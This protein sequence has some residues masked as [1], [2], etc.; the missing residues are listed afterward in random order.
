MTKRQRFE[1]FQRDGFTCRYCGQKPPDVILE[2]DHIVPICAGGTDDPANLVTSCFA[3]NRGKAGTPLVEAPPPLGAIEVLAAI[4]EL[5]ERKHLLQAQ[6]V[7]ARDTAVFQ[8]EALAL[9]TEWLLECIPNLEDRHIQKASLSVF[10]D[11][12]GPDGVRE[13]VQRAALQGVNKSSFSAWR[14]FCGVCWRLIKQNEEQVA[15]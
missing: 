10:L 6:I 5:A 8:R 9:A 1:T 13:A 4:Q 2:V 7:L 11:R 12:L 3:C 15:S 14:W